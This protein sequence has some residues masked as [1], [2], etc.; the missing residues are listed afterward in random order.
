MKIT[1]LGCGGSGGV[2]LVTGEW[3]QCNPRNPYN[4]RRRVSVFVQH[5]GV[6]ILIDTSPDLR[7]QMLDAH[8]KR[9]DAVLY[10]HGHADHIY[11]LHEL[12]YFKQEDS[13][14][15][16][17][18]PVTMK[19]VRNAFDYAFKSNHHFY[20]TFVSSH[21]HSGQPFEIMG[22]QIIP[23][24]QDHMTTTSWGY[25]IGNFAYSTDFKTIPEESLKLLHGLD[26]W[27]VDCLSLDPHPTHSDFHATKALIDRLNP[28]KAIL[29]HMNH[30]LDYD[31]ALS[32]CDE[33]I[34]P[35]HDGM[36]IQI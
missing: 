19:I 34:L 14:P 2:P 4:R 33:R 20:D 11:G 24:I 3:G 9:V 25:R 36:V 23:F 32:L 8:V 30:H 5:Q 7:Q 28:K 27:I 31:V 10:T 22:V 17:G 6:N 21:E 15:L 1:V 35:A 18:D 13:I 12:R 26:L 16:Y 29:T